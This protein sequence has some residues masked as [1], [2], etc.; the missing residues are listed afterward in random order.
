MQGG[1]EK[2][3][4]VFTKN[5]QNKKPALEIETNSDHDA[6]SKMASTHPLPV[7]VDDHKTVTTL[8]SPS[9]FKVSQPGTNSEMHEPDPALKKLQQ[10]MQKKAS[11]KESQPALSK[12]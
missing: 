4:T 6:N 8:T 5:M 10:P 12:I 1:K 7:H 3:L 9:N 2:K 11:L